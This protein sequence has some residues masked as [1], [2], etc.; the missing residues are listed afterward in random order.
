MTD[1]CWHLCGVRAGVAGTEH[2][3]QAYAPNEGVVAV[4]AKN[5]E[6]LMWYLPAT[7]EVCADVAHLRSFSS[8][9]PIDYKELSVIPCLF[10]I[11]DNYHLLDFYLFIGLNWKVQVSYFPARGLTCLHCF[12]VTE[13]Q[14]LVWSDSINL[15]P[16][17]SSTKTHQNHWAE[18]ARWFTRTVVRLRDVSFPPPRDTLWVSYRSYSFYLCWQRKDDNCDES[19][20]QWNIILSIFLTLY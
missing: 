18:T 1:V 2:T 5:T 4:L 14:E 3:L 16:R 13:K 7:A 17:Q 12:S 20:G 6:Q 10:I 11:I 19:A 8:R 15:S 9:I